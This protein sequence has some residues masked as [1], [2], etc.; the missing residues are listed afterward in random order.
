M[1][2]TQIGEMYVQLDFISKIL[3]KLQSKKVVP[4][5]NNNYTRFGELNQSLAF[6]TNGCDSRQ[7]PQKVI[8]RIDQIFF[9]CFL[10]KLSVFVTKI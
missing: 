2:I 10:C 6:F 8:I 4:N 5:N 7:H 1:N 9:L 3:T